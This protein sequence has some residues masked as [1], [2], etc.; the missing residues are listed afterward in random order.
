MRRQSPDVYM[1]DACSRSN[2]IANNYVARAFTTLSS[3]APANC[4]VQLIL[5]NIDVDTC[6][7]IAEFLFLIKL[8][9]KFFGPD[10]YYSFYY[11]SRGRDKVFKITKCF[12]FR[13]IYTFL[14]LISV[15]TLQFCI[16]FFHLKILF[17]YAF[18]LTSSLCFNSK[19]LPQ[20]S[21]CKKIDCQSRIY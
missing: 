1:A 11:A 2:K 5:S 17:R 21:Y 7:Q 16:F 9:L 3:G 8:T 19:T 6:F 15:C 12:N 18:L 20:K 13:S 10:L 14:I 4:R